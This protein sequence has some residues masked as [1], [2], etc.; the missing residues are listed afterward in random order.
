MPHKPATRR[1]ARVG[2]W[3]GRRAASVAAPARQHPDSPHLL[4]GRVP[5]AAPPPTPTPAPAP[6]PAPWEQRRY[7]IAER[8]LTL[9]RQYRVEGSEGQLLAYVAQ[10]WMRLKEAWTVYTDETKSAVAFQV[11]ATKV[12]DFQANLEVRDAA[13]TLLGT[14]RRK[15][16]K[17]IV[18]DHWQ[19][20]GP[21]G[22]VHGELHEP[23]GRGLARRMLSRLVPYRASV[24]DGSGEQVARVEGTLQLWGDTYDLHVDRPVLDPRVLCCLVVVVDSLLAERGSLLD[25]TGLG[26]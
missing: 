15:G 16:W 7:R 24:T 23:T 1:P 21:D 2:G 13:G 19:V 9:G 6:Q 12:F 20:L 26:S 18:A 17:S 14:L 3:P 10:R 11:K 25:V 8:R 22:F 4:W 5:T